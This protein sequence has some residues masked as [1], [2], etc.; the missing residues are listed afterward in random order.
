MTRFSER[1]GG[2]PPFSSGLSEASDKLRTATWNLL[3]PILLPIELRQLSNYQEAATAIWGHLHWATDEVPHNGYDGRRTLKGQWFRCDWLAF[4]DVFEFC[5][6]LVARLHESKRHSW[7]IL[8]NQ[9]LEQQ[10]CAYRFISEELAPI[11]NP[12]EMAEVEAA[13]E[14]AIG[15]V[16]THIRSALEQLP[17]NPK[18]SARN[19]IKESISAVEATFKELTDSPSA[20]FG[21]GLKAFEAKCGPLHPS[22]RRGFEKLY[23][24]TNGPEGIRHALDD[25]SREVTVDDARFMLIACSAF[26]NYLVAIAGTAIAQKV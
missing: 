1:V 6:H 14:C 18:T 5:V 3:H 24:Y 2:Q 11:T 4:F 12:L 9:L 7:F 10:G 26:A 15:A 22:L 19:S 23:A 20:T 16:A 21:D 13:A 17:P 25:D 8:V